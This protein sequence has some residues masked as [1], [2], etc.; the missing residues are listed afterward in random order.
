MPMPT[1]DAMQ[2]AVPCCPGVSSNLSHGR[3]HRQLCGRALRW[4]QEA[5]SWNC[6]HHGPRLDGAE[7]AARLGG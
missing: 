6:D 5:G 3:T 7:A 1:I 2:D 4:D